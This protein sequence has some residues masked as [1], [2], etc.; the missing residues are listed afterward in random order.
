M[1]LLSVIASSRRR[2]TFTGL[3][4]LYPGAAAAY[5]LRV[6]RA[7]ALNDPIVRVRRD[8]DND[9][10]DVMADLSVM[11]SGNYFVTLDSPLVGSSATFGD[12]MAAN[13]GFVP[14]WYDPTGNGRHATQTTA[15]N[16]PQIVASGALTLF[17]TGKPGIYFEDT[18][19][20]VVGSFL[21]SDPWLSVDVSE[22]QFFAPFSFAVTNRNKSIFSFLTNLGNNTTGVFRN[23]DRALQ[24]AESR[25]GGW[26]T[27]IVS[28]AGSLPAGTYMLTSTSVKGGNF[29]LRLNGAETNTGSN[30]SGDLSEHT[31]V[32]IGGQAE[33][34]AVWQNY[35]PELIAYPNT[36][37]HTAIEANINAAWS[38]Y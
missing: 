3:L 13:N 30:T 29:T 23:T 12:F 9:E 10:A 21:T 16:Q 5:S 25:T 15:A 4:D 26:R 37:N 8:S 24:N 11:T 19:F 14:I 34:N 18:N 36:E 33:A 1:D 38:V 2:S 31:S 28:G 17:K 35:L 6:L 20:S 32:R 7:A 27:T 22:W